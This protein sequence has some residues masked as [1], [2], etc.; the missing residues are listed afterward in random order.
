MTKYNYLCISLSICPMK[1]GDD[2]E[3]DAAASMPQ[4]YGEMDIDTIMNGK[5]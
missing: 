4:D 3:T 2:D 1:V 5:V